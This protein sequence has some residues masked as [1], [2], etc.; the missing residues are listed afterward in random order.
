[1]RAKIWQIFALIFYAVKEEGLWLLGFDDN[2]VQRWKSG[3][4]HLAMPLLKGL[5]YS[6]LEMLRRLPLG[7]VDEAESG[8]RVQ[9]LMQSGR[10]EARSLFKALSCGLPAFEESF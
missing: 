1:M 3:K 9:T 6:G 7:N 10:D 5:A 2:L 4:G 8:L